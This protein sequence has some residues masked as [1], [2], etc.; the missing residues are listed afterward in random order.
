MS[1]DG[2]D[3]IKNLQEDKAGMRREVR[4]KENGIFFQISLWS[5]NLW[6]IWPW[7]CGTAPWSLAESV[8]ELSKFGK[9]IMLH[10]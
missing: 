4:E 10:T 2:L 7:L 3:K 8:Q 9:Q 6:A 5:E 1:Y